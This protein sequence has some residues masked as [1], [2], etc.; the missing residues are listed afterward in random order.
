V[1]V[2]VFVFVCVCVC[3][4]IRAHIGTDVSCVRTVIVSSSFRRACLSHWVEHLLL[5]GRKWHGVSLG[6]LRNFDLPGF[7]LFFLYSMNQKK[8][9]EKKILTKIEMTIL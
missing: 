9:K 4:C 8:E 6:V 5:Y 1:C 7:S 3:V 2:C